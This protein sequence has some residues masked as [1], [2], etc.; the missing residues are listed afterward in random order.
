MRISCRSVILA[1]VAAQFLS[2][3]GFPIDD[4]EREAAVLEENA[5]R[6]MD[7]RLPGS[8]PFRLTEDVGV[9]THGGKWVE[10]SYTLIW[11]GPDRWRDE[12]TFPDYHEVQVGGEQSF[13]RIRNPPSRTE[14][15]VRARSVVTPV[16]IPEGTTNRH[17][18]RIYETRAGEMIAKCVVAKPF[19]LRL[20]EF[21]F[22]AERGLLVH[23]G[24]KDPTGIESTE[25]N[26]YLNL[27]GK[28]LP[29]QRRDFR[30]GIQVAEV[31]VR[32]ASMLHEVDAASFSPPAGGVQIPHCHDPAPPKA[33]IHPDPEYTTS[34]RINRITGTVVLDV[35]IGMQG[36][37]EDI[38]LLEA[39]DPGLDHAAVD[40]LRKRWRF[41]PAAC[42]GTPVPADLRVEVS[43]RQ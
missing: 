4:K 43:F 29:R 31:K 23:R 33:I 8:P 2:L 6:L 21:C 32:D 40:T 26:D 11:A 19:Q 24:A 7:L 25:L 36:H 13:W 16:K 39:L 18:K 35:E 22:D 15:A 42:S 34:A 5:K 41:E 38:V 9:R 30:K 3:P 12:L 10:G 28:F 27:G 14:A 1:V 17:I 37:I 20:V